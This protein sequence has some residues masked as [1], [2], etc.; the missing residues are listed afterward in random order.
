MK[1]KT[2]LTL[3][4]IS[5]IV[6]PAYAAVQ[7]VKIGGDLTMLGITRKNFDLKDVVNDVFQSNA[8]QDEREHFAS[9]I[10][11]RLDADLTEN[12]ATTLRLINE[13]DWDVEDASNA[14]IDLDLAYITLKEFMMSP[15]TLTVGRQE[16]HFGNDLII[17]DPNSA[18]TLLGGDF[19]A[20]DLSMRKSFDSVK[21]TVDL[22]DYAPVTV[23]AIYAIIDES[24]AASDALADT[25][26]SANDDVELFGVN[27]R[28][29]FEN[30]YD[31]I[32]EGYWFAKKTGSSAERTEAYSDKAEYIHNL[33]ARGSMEIM[34]DLDIQLETAY[35]FGDYAGGVFG[36]TTHKLGSRSAWIIQAIADYDLP[37][38]VE[39]SPTMS[40]SLT[41]ASGED[42]VDALDGEYTAWDPMYENQTTPSIMNTLFYLGGATFTLEGSIKPIEDLTVKLL[43]GYC[44]LTSDY[45]LPNPLTATP[46]YGDTLYITDEADGLGWETDLVVT[47]DYT[48]D[49]Q[50]GVQTGI[51]I[52]GAALDE[53][54]Q[55]DSQYNFG[56]QDHAWE[57]IA[58]MKVTF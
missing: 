22:S 30:D 34:E 26:T 6:M 50:L 8:Y 42:E 14:D 12:V 27:A 16:L 45:G 44:W 33:G 58:S 36:R 46:T 29:D 7:N 5:L 23:D 43:Y 20:G 19:E 56:N 2:L 17:G 55:T 47:Y 25:G 24:T 1:L 11:I 32:A 51:F 13:R 21:L 48:E 31:A 4:L 41:Y 38:L 49:V 40:T 10:R 28:Y 54:Y 3:A 35:Q 15:I 37:I 18:Q 39:Y 57:A 52:P 9:I 53:T